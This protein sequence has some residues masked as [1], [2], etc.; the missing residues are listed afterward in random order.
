[1]AFTDPQSITVNAVARSLPRILTGSSVG[2]FVTADGVTTLTVDPTGTKARRISKA[3]VRE[4]V[5][6]T[7]SVTGLISVQNHSFTI[8]ANRP[9]TGISDTVAEQLASGL[10]A[11]L[12]AGS[13]AN[14]KK[15]LAGE[16]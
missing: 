7:D 12:T 15:I 6:V 14:L 8:I 4:N 3:S 5:N 16:N 9:K 2:T 13:N 1:V 11:W 10:I